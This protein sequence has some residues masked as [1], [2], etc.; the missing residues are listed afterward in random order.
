MKTYACF[1]FKQP[2]QWEMQ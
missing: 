2:L 1:A